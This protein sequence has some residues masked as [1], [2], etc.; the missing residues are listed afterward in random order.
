M[1]IEAAYNLLEFD[2]QSFAE[3]E[4]IIKR[5]MFQ[6]KIQTLVVNKNIL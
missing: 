6:I 4:N 1:I 5:K 2:F 3:K